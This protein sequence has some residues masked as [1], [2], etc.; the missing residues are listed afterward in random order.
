MPKHFD[1]GG[2]G[3]S[4]RRVVMMRLINL[5]EVLCRDISPPELFYGRVSRVGA[6]PSTNSTKRRALRAQMTEQNR[7]N[8]QGTP[9]TYVLV[10]FEGN[11]D[12]RHKTP[13][14]RR[15]GGILPCSSEV[16]PTRIM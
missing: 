14:E 7:E 9:P 15:I 3:G 16:G 6:C 11:K 5:S 10:R 2:F 4:R 12:P 13:Q 8:A 1:F